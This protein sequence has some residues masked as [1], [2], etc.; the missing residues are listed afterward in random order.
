MLLQIKLKERRS[1]PLKQNNKEEKDTIPAL[2]V[3]SVQE[4]LMKKL[5]LIQNQPLLC[6]IFKEPPII[7][8]KKGKLWQTTCLRPK[9]LNVNTRFHAGIYTAIFRERL[10]QKLCTRQSRKVIWDMI[11]TLVPNTV[12]VEPTFVA[13]L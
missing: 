8:Y 6:Q 1:A 11:N 5:N 12:A 3:S 13:L 9:I 4:A 10:S 2:S 7:S